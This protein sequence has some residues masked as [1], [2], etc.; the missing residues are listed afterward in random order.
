MQSDQKLKKVIVPSSVF[1]K[2][3]CRLLNIPSSKSLPRR[4]LISLLILLLRVPPGEFSLDE[5]QPPF[6]DKF[7]ISLSLQQW[8]NSQLCIMLKIGSSQ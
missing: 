8:L 5:M 3:K 6:K 1:K 4:D 7:S 2:L